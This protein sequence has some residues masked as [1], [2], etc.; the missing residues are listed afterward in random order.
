M[1]ISA[2]QSI[3]TNGLVNSLLEAGFDKIPL[4]ISSGSSD[5]QS[6]L[7]P[8]ELVV[9]IPAYLTGLRR[10]FILATVCAAGAFISSLATKFEKIKDA[11]EQKDSANT[12][13]TTEDSASS[14]K[15]MGQSQ[16]ESSLP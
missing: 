15:Q 5:L 10:A 13:D 2:A 11:A 16:K 4:V 7:T 14:S 3:F 1:F 8:D 6:V 9:V 12:S